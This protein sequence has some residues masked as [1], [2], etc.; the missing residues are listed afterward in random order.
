MQALVYTAPRAVEVRDWPEPR[1]G[2]GEVLVQVH[3]AGLCGSD[4]HGFLGHSKIR[5]PPMVMGHEFAG[6][7]VE[8]GPGVERLAVGDRVTVQP[9]VGCGHCA[10]CLSGYPNACADRRLMGG[11]LQGAF[12]QRIAAPQQ[13]VYRLPNHV[14][15]AQAAM[16]E[17]LANGM[18]MARLAPAS[19][20][21]VVVIGAGTLGLMTLQAYKATGAR[22]VVVL[23]RAADRLAVATRLGADATGNTADSDAGAVVSGALA[24]A[25]PSIVVDAVGH[26]VTR[27]QALALVA[28]RGT[29]VLLGL[30]EA[31]SSLDFLSAINREVRLQCSYGSRDEDFRDALNLIA[32][33]R[34]D[35]T[36]W[37][38]P[39]RLDQGQETF[40]RLVDDPRG[41]VK[42]VF[43]IDGA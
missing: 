19:Y 13:L 41:L 33:G 11:H 34:A 42:A 30:A 23:D 26:T 10:Q 14:S 35:V 25:Q 24:G 22:R 8:L 31:E 4:L 3:A 32:D 43:M 36:S 16:V 40:T 39:M 9:L 5:V 18:H 2:Y 21:D 6:E 37:V 27:Q 1:P 20:Q 38:E 15:Y 12:A 28:P 29:V 17:P 7:I